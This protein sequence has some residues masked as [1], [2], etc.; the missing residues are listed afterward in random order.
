MERRHFP[1]HLALALLAVAGCASPAKLT[2]RSHRALAEGDLRKAYETARRALEKDPSYAD[3]RTAFGEAATAIA[4]D[5]RTRIARTAEVD[6]V[7]AARAALEFR[8]F[9]AELARQ[10]VVIAADPNDIELE[11]VL[12]AGAARIRYQEAEQSLRSGR[13]KEAYRRFVESEDFDPNYRDVRRRV[14]ETLERALTE[15]AILPFENQTGVRDLSPAIAEQMIRESDRGTGSPALF[16]TRVVDLESVLENTSV[17]EMM[18]MTRDD[19]IGIGRRLDADRVVYGR[20]TGLQVDNSTYDFTVPVFHKQIDKV[21][22]GPDRVRWIES[23]VEV[24]ARERHVRVVMQ[25]EVIDTHNGD[26]LAAREVPRETFARVA[27][28][29][30]RAEGDCDDYAFVP[31]PGTPGRERARD[32]ED[33]WKKTMGSWSLPAFLERARKDPSRREWSREYRGEFAHDTRGRPVFLGTLPAVED[34]VL[35]ALHDAEEPVIRTLRELD[36]DD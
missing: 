9:R 28:S 33:R 19:A 22:D 14:P 29:D 25:Y 1:L 8:D 27:W 15:V 24:R 13:P 34:M 3:A 35:L 32:S 4:I 20:L 21:A 18:R 5:H 26:V 2:E 11:A 36:P 31:D 6:T 7:A 12:C 16:F 30:Y 10:P 23:R 17:A